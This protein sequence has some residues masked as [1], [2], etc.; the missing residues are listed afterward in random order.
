MPLLN[1]AAILPSLVQQVRNALMD[2]GVQWN[3]VLVN[4]GSTDDSPTIMDQM[5]QADPGILCVHLSRNFGHQSALQAGLCHAPGEAVIAMDS[6]GQDSPSAIGPMIRAWKEGYH[7][8]YAVRRDRK[9]VWLKRFLF[10][11]FYR[12]LAR[13]A[14]TVIPRDAG[15]FG[16]MDRSVVDQV[17][18]LP[19][20]E[21]FF[22]G[23]RSWVGYRQLALPV[24]RM[25]RHDSKPRV[26]FMGLVA[27]A[28]TALFGFSRVPL[29]AFYWLAMI[30]ALVSVAC[31]GFAVFHKLFTG[32]AIPGWASSTSVAAFFG[33][34]NSL[35][36]A[37]LGEYIAR[38]YDQVRGRPMYVVARTVNLTRENPARGHSQ[39][40]SP[41]DLTETG[42][43]ES[44]RE[45]EQTIQARAVP[46]PPDAPRG[47]TASKVA[48]G[49]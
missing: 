1:E 41:V 5:A 14:S 32:L 10:S 45:I 27:L 6:D 2:A 17:R 15:N 13:T 12:I 3:I 42:L 30:S 18:W 4:D 35:G 19:E 37:I 29:L 28:R 48:R 33:A 43:L 8:V 25:A 34:I 7:V 21:R 22:P 38:I 49:T 11:A 40:P 24:E 26:R 44:V 46:V 16:L 31:I 23:L 9:E 47:A 20:S 36:I 39:T